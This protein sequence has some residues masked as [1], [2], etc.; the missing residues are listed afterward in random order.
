MKV[1]QTVPILALVLYICGGIS[2]FGGVGVLAISSAAY[3][4]TGFTLLI[5]GVLLSMTGVMLMRISR[6]RTERLLR[7]TTPKV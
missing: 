2:T 3:T 1:A 5:G 4:T 6:N 7:C